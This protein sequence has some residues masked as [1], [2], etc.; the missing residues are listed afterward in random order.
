MS[1]IYIA[2]A[3]FMMI[4]MVGFAVFIFYRGIQQKRSINYIHKINPQI[5]EKDYRPVLTSR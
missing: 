2:F 1:A 5:I 4:A 3:I